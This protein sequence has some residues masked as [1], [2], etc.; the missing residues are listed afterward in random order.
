MQTNQQ[1]YSALESL[2]HLSSYSITYI[3]NN[4]FYSKKLLKLKG[5]QYSQHRINWKRKCRP[6]LNIFDV[7]KPGGFFDM[8]KIH[9]CF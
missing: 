7:H 6:L 8:R 2:R 4:S 3:M 1:M 5:L 9:I